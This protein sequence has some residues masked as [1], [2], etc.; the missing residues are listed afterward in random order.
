MATYV[1]LLRAVNV[2]GANMLPMSRL[3]ELCAAAGFADVATYIQSG[4]VVFSAGGGR[5][6]AQRDLEEALAAELGKP[7]GVHLRT[8]AELA[9]ILERD[10]FPDAPRSKVLVFF[11][12]HAPPAGALDD[13][14]IPGREEVRLSGRE[15]FV[16]FPDGSGRSKLKIPFAKTATSRNLNTVQKLLELARR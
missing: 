5:A 9:S 8:P 7:V 2:G 3:R 11:L 6:A 14:A 16:H 10:P 4:N 1:A 13:L 15:V 12:D